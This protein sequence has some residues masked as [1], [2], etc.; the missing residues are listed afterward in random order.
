MV[1]KISLASMV[2]AVSIICSSLYAEDEPPLVNHLV[3]CQL[4]VKTTS[5]EF[6]GSNHAAWAWV[7]ENFNAGNIERVY[8]SEH[9]GMTMFFKTKS[10]KEMQVLVNSNPF[11]K[12]GIA[13]CTSS[14]IGALIALS[15]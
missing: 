1:K 8:L 14:A 13:D 11:T 9:N 12:K 5:Q 6:L 4:N 15:K 3:N 7:I 10:E 2:L